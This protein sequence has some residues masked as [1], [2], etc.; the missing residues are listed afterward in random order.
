MECLG[1]CMASRSL[2]ASNETLKFEI[3]LHCLALAIY[4]Y[5]N[6][7]VRDWLASRVRING[8]GWDTT[9][10]LWHNVHIHTI[11]DRVP[12]SSHQVWGTLFSSLW[13]HNIVK[14]MLNP[15][16]SR[17]V[18]KKTLGKMPYY[19][20][21]WQCSHTAWKTGKMILV[22]DFIFKIQGIF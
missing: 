11:K 7:R 6:I 5:I 19:I 9:T 1:I 14:A 10:S 13:D 4:M 20:Y 15:N 22:R 18:F 16:H 17:A 12:R 8:L 3:L 2:A 21:P